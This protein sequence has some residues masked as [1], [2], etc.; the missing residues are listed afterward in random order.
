MWVPGTCY[1]FSLHLG[2]VSAVASVLA[3][4]VPELIN[5][6]WG[7]PD[8]SMENLGKQVAVTFRKMFIHTLAK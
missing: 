6:A 1:D 7:G 4:C 5:A 2:E 8:I 3:P